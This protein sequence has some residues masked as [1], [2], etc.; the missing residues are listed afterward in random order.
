[1]GSLVNDCKPLSGAQSVAESDLARVVGVCGGV[2]LFPASAD[3]DLQWTC[4]SAGLQRRPL[5]SN[6][7]LRALEQT[8]AVAEKI[9]IIGLWRSTILERNKNLK[10][11]RHVADDELSIA[12]NNVIESCIPSAAKVT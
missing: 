3:C 5:V 12:L 2:G 11:K 1:M 9:G 6:T 4:V 10:H 7:M 8:P